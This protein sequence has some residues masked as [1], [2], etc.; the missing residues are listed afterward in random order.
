MME[1]FYVNHKNQKIDLGHSPYQMQI[2]D[3]F[4]SSNKYEGNNNRV[5]RIYKDISTRSTTVTIDA[6]SE[7]EFYE[8]INTFFEVIEVDNIANE[9]GRLYVGEYCLYCNI[10]SSN[11]TFWQE[12]FRGMENS[13]KILAPY[14]FWCREVTKSFLKGNVAVEGQSTEEFLYYPYGYPYAYSMPQDAGFL[15]NDHYAACDF[16]MIV[17]G[18]CTNPSILINGHL[19]E[20][21]TTLYAGEYLVVDSRENTVLRHMNDGRTENLFNRRN[22]DSSLFEKI[23]NGHCSVLWNTQAFGFDIILFQERSEPK[24]IL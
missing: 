1:V 4:N 24:W 6:G 7:K 17:Y 14:P 13:V 15:Q 5:A 18:P 21:I 22:K 19:Y 16:K 23:P 2:G 8:A 11:K 9:R 10:I 3:I 12:T 20:V